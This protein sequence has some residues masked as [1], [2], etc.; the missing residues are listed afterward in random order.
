MFKT[1]RVV[2]VSAAAALTF[3]GL[4]GGG[5]VLAEVTDN[6]T[7]PPS[8]ATQEEPKG[9]ASLDAYIAQLAANLGISEDALR[10]AINKTNLDF[11]DKAVAE[12]KLTEEQAA[13]IRERLEAGTN[14]FFGLGPLHLPRGDGE[15]GFLGR[16]FG[17]HGEG[18]LHIEREGGPSLNIM[19]GLLQATE[20]TAAFLGISVEGLRSALSDGKSLS[21]IAEENGKTSD[22]LKTFLIGRATEE[23]DAMVA[24]GTLTAEQGTK[25][26]DVL[27]AHID[28]ILDATRPAMGDR[29]FPVFGG[30]ERH[31]VPGG[32]MFPG[33]PGDEATPTEEAPAAGPS[34]F[35]NG[36]R[37]TAPDLS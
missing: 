2:A 8:F 15:G 13:E 36:G 23:I 12:G 35:R 6:T 10:E 9:K 11:V 3:G 19:G 4:V 34:S 25:L 7:Q 1:H 17:G 29:P 30:P 32:K 22:E 16:I 28:H 20:E 31:R 37:T 14:G 18:G 26:K 27:N 24:A 33:G 21:A 5:I